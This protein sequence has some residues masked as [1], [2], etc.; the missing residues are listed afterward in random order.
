M[1]KAIFYT[2]FVPQSVAL[3]LIDL[4]RLYLTG[5][6]TKLGTYVNPHGKRLCSCPK[7]K[8]C[9]Y[10]RRYQDPLAR[11]GWDSYRETFVYG[12]SLD[13][14]C[15]YSLEHTCQ[16][17]LVIGLFDAQRHDPVLGIAA[18]HE[19]V[20]KLHLPVKVATFDKASDA[21]GFYRLCYEHCDVALVVAL[22]NATRGTFATPR[23][24]WTST[25]CPDAPPA[26]RW[27]AGATA[28][29]ANV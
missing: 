5:D 24:R 7:Q 10:P 19:A 20:D 4:Q 12:Q 2:L 28:G 16:L 8:P 23:R 15:A 1:L 3:G 26:G 21:L 18:L 17:P 22:N 25:A 14:L 11:W 6:S 27:S 13:E 9:R 29:I